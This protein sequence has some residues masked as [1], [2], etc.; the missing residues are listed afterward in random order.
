MARRNSASFRLSLVAVLF[1]L[2]ALCMT[3]GARAS[4]VGR[5]VVVRQADPIAFSANPLAAAHLRHV[6]HQRA[7][8]ALPRASAPPS[9]LKAACVVPPDFAE[10]LL[11]RENVLALG[12]AAR[13]P[14]PSRA[15]PA[16]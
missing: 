1:G 14:G 15:P 12:G 7:V 16:S 5:C 9:L 3:S 10:A 11:V 2:S 6:S 13:A 8:R 4:E